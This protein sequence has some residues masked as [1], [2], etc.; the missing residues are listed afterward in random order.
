MAIELGLEN[1]TRYASNETEQAKRERRNRER[2]YLVLFVHDRSLSM[3]TGRACMLPEV[4][5]ECP[6]LWDV[7]IAM[8]R[9]TWYAVRKIGIIRG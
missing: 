3:L 5:T 7:L 8:P 6:A 9:M 2:T 4:R 1:Y